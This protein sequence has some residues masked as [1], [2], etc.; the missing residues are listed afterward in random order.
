MIL[1]QLHAELL[2]EFPCPEAVETVE[3][4]LEKNDVAVEEVGLL[5]IPR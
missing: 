3:I 4:G 2:T 5:W 1:V